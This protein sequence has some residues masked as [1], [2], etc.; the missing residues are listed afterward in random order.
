MKQITV[1]FSQRSFANL[2]LLAA[3]AVG[4]HL[5]GCSPTGAMR[6]DAGVNR[7]AAAE[8]PAY[9]SAPSLSEEEAAR[10]DRLW[11][12][13]AGSSASDDYPIGPGDVVTIS[14]P[15]V[16]EL[17]Q[18]RARVSAE[19]LI[20]LPLVGFVQAQGLTEDGLAEEIDN[21]LENIMYKPQ[22]SVF[23]DEYR[24]R[25]A[26]VV[27]E[28]NKPGMVLLDTP[29]ETILDV[30]TQAG[31]VSSS[32]ADEVILIA[33]NPGGARAVRSLR[34]MREDHDDATA[35]MRPA[36][37]NAAVWTDRRLP[38]DRANG[39]IDRASAAAAAEFATADV[40]KAVRIPLRSDSLTG[41]ERYLSLPVRPGD[42]LVVPGG[43]QV[44]VVGWVQS[45]GHFSVGSGLTVLGAIGAAG[46]PMYAANR[47]A[48]ALI[49]NTQDG[50]KETILLDVDKIS[51]GEAPDVAVKANDVIDV[52]YSGLRIGPYIFYSI[53]TRVGVSGPTIPY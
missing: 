4:I 41:G 13:R 51:R 2:V 17:E 52:P 32:A 24:K 31:G 43:G 10:L 47:R 1:G 7:S 45:P 15:E 37:T 12:Q 5:A 48:V 39:S 14:V 26:A 46:G 29:S 40:A 18:R 38:A 21:K 22:A 35:S 11:Q 25:E 30:L 34:V 19:G 42:V 9:T 33:A 3:V 6:L 50:S 44:M 23:V 28:V 20:E 16:E 27:G 36:S 53:L 49:R 8:K